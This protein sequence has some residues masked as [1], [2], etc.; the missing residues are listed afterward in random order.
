MDTPKPD[1]NIS[2]VSPDA[3]LSSENWEGQLAALAAERDRL[4]VEK[5]ELSDR[6]LR[7]RAEFD[8]ASRDARAHGTQQHF[9]QHALVTHHAVQSREVSPRSDR[10]VHGSGEAAA[11]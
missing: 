8:N 3:N 2:D 6:M 1:A 5:S 4:A 10:R 7:A 11:R 9:P